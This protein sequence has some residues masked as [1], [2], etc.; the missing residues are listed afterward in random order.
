MKYLILTFA[1]TLFCFQSSGQPTFLVQ[2]ETPALVDEIMSIDLPSFDFEST[3]FMGK[4]TS[5]SPGYLQNIK[6]LTPMQLNQMGYPSTNLSETNSVMMGTLVHQ[7]IMLGNTKAT[8]TYVFDINGNMV[9][10]QFTIP[11]GN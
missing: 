4:S 3:D 11:I 1:L 9:N 8:S 6:V 7:H 10:H 2:Q 5:T